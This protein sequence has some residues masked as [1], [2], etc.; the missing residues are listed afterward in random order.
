MVD[1]GG[2]ENEGSFQSGWRRIYMIL[3]GNWGTGVEA[4]VV[5]LKAHLYETKTSRNPPNKKK[6]LQS[7]IITVFSALAFL[8]QISHIFSAGWYFE[9]N[10]HRPL[11]HIPDIPQVVPKNW[12]IPF[13]N[14]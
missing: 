1:S 7:L 2:S 13:I 9:E 5:F 14:R 11:E 4:V 6:N 8:V 12:M 3:R 10:S